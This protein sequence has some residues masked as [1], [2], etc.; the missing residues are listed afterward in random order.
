M[1]TTKDGDPPSSS[2]TLLL[3]SIAP[4]IMG[5]NINSKTT[6]TAIV[7]VDLFIVNLIV[8]FTS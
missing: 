6:T 8:F 3:T 2:L 7:I 1:L 5:I 4:C